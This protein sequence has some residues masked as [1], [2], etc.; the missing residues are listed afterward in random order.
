V[1]TRSTI[2]AVDGDVAALELLGRQLGSEFRVLSARNAEEALAL[3]QTEDVGLLVTERALPGAASGLELAERARA[4]D[5]DLPVLLLTAGA[6]PHGLLAALNAGRIFRYVEKPWDPVSLRATVKAALEGRSLRVERDTLVDRLQRRIESLSILYDVAA[7]SGDMGSYSEIVQLIMGALG[8]ILRFDVAATLIAPSEGTGAA[9]MHMHCQSPCDELTLT[10]TRDRCIELYA[11][12]TGRALEE[13]QLSV[14]ISGERV[15]ETQRSHRPG[16]STHVPLVVD[17]NVVGI[18]FVAAARSRAFTLDDEKLLYVLANQ[19]SDAVRRMSNRFVEERRKLG[20]MVESMADGVVMTDDSGEVFLIN[21][22]ARRMLGIA[23]DADATRKYLKDKLGFYPFDLVVVAGGVVREEL[24]IGDQVLH[25]IVSPV[26]DKTSKVV[27]TVVVL[28][29]ITERKELDRR[30]EEFV[31]VVSHELRTPLTSIAGALDIVL[32]GNVG[33]IGD[34]QRRYLELARDSCSKLNVIVDDLLDVARFERGKMAMTF[35]PMPLDALARDCTDRYRAA[36]EAKRVTLTFRADG[37]IR[38]VGDADRLTQVLHNLLSNAI[39]FTPDG[40][41]IEVEVFGPGVASSHVG[42]SVWNNGETIPEHDR[43][44]VFDKF[45]QVQASST[46]RVGGTGLGLAI[47]RAIVEGHGGRIWVENAPSGTKFVFTLPSAPADIVIDDETAAAEPGASRGQPAAPRPRKSIELPAVGESNQEGKQV[48]VVDAD[49]YSAY[50]L[51]GA[52]MAAGHRVHVAHDADE[53]LSWAREKKPE[54]I[55]V[56]ILMPGID[57]LALVEILKHDPETRKCPVVVISSATRE[58]RAIGAGADGWLPKPV[59]VVALRE[60]STRLIAERGR[61]ARIKVMVVDDDAGIRMISREVL[62]SAGYLVREAE[63]GYQAIEDARTF[64][65]DLMLLD[66]MMPDLDGFATAKRFRSE[67]A[68]AMTPVIFVSAR[69]QTADKVRAFKLGADDYLVKPF[70]AAELVARVEKALERRGRELDAS[71]TTKLPGAGAIESEIERRLAE[72]GDLAFCY[73][74][75]DNLKAF[76]DYYGYAKAD[77]VIRQT[78]D[79]VREVIA[80]EGGP[81]DFIGHIAGDD[82]VFITSSERVDRVCR[83]ICESF[84][85]LVPLYY[86]KGDREIGYIEA[87]DRYGVTRRFPIMSV[88][89]AALTTQRG[90]PSPFKSY[91]DLAAAAAEA[92]HRAKA[93]PGSSYVRDADV[94]VPTKAA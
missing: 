77:G 79:L 86:N 73:L 74:D 28:R 78:G 9:V 49:R 12:L 61:A 82:F 23:R 85:R 58:Q 64:R 71:P 52:L 8:K 2:L 70:D 81:E 76:N 59:D 37:N 87:P 17:A 75:L 41:R 68:G 10:D 25:S 90:Q 72:G 35:S 40:G 62:E 3:I 33:G 38:I 19:T 48:L 36:T 57:G 69:S 44:R 29:D 15:G 32:K 7:A 93:I 91:A 1:S 43:E 11:T 89:I 50:I 14:Q 88:S 31:S 60:L 66:V 18:I 46:R 26:V 51:K 30:K 92:K 65:P 54:L 5:P 80:R 84:D 24:K 34:K 42:V 83:S 39:K 21:P 67:A 53:A 6:E 63:N 55:T 56:D 13:G 22:A 94:V 20:L 47:S 27:G 4:Y 16:S 45:E